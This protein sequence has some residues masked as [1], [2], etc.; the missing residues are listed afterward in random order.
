M[1]LYNACS[2]LDARLIAL[3]KCN[4][5]AVGFGAPWLQAVFMAG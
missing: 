2:R 1:N 3:I 5:A 4:K